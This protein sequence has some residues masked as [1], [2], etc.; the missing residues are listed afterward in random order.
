MRW[1]RKLLNLVR[2]HRLHHD[3]ERELSFHINE[4]ADEFIAS[5]MNKDDALRTARR[6]FGNYRQYQERT[7]DMDIHV[8]LETLAKDLR[9]AVRGLRKNPGF[10]A[11][12]VIT[13]AVGIGATTTV[14]TVLNG[15]LIKPLPYS[16]PERLVGVWHSAVFQGTTTNDFNLSPP[17]YVVY[18]E[19]NRTFQHFGVWRNF[20]ANVTGIGNPEQVRSLI[21][22]H[23][24]L[25]ALAV[26]PLMGRWFSQADD[27]PGSPETVI[28][29][30]GYWQRAFGGDKSVV[31]RVITVDSRPREIIGVMPESYRFLRGDPELILPQR[32]GGNLAQTNSDY[33]YL[34][35]ARLRPGVTLAQANADVARMLPIWDQKGTEILRLGPALRPLKENVVGDIGNVLWVLMGTV[36]MVLL[37]ACANVANL[38]LVRA[39]GRGNSRFEPRW[40]RVG[41]ESCASCSPGH[42]YLLCW[43][44]CSVCCLRAGA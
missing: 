31:S 2:Q 44:E 36:G 21:V 20:P 27:T 38:L 14:F 18:Q 34:G 40:G 39:V 13:L 15:I 3:I 9:Y 23:G 35:L 25:P 30:Y 32:F 17:M 19:Q 29:T 6:Q 5:G 43:V 4:R 26:Q 42:S 24:V 1:Y 37:I 33:F 16:E 12:A 10:T 11:A 8:W 7:R 28:L 22:T 41:A